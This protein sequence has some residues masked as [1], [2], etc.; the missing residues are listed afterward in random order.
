MK[1]VWLTLFSKMV[2]AYC[3]SSTKHKII[4]FPFLMFM[5]VIYI[6]IYSHFSKE[7]MTRSVVSSDEIGMR[8][9]VTIK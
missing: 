2:A 3:D 9:V 4:F 8:Y 5:L 6:Y 7:L 1:T